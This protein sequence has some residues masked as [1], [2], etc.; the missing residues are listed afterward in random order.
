MLTWTYFVAGAVNPVWPQEI[1]ASRIARAPSQVKPPTL[2]TL[3][4]AAPQSPA[5]E[6]AGAQNAS[7]RHCSCGNIDVVSEF[8]SRSSQE[9]VA[10]WADEICSRPHSARAHEVIGAALP[11]R[12]SGDEEEYASEVWERLERGG[13]TG[14]SGGTLCHDLHTHVGRPVLQRDLRLRRQ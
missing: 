5:P 1:P 4:Q 2:P 7:D 11:R 8:T 12:R 6:S 9:I 3:P 13:D 14:C 10:E